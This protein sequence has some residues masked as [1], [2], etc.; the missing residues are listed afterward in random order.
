VIA[1]S[2]IPRRSGMRVKTDR[3]DARN[4]ARLQRGARELPAHNASGCIIRPG[5][6]CSTRLLDRATSHAAEA[7]EEVQQWSKD[8]RE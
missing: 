8:V 7:S 6:V 4:L 3:I 1:P 2:L 5:P